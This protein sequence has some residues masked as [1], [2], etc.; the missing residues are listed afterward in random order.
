MSKKSHSNKVL[1]CKNSSIHVIDEI[2]MI[3]NQTYIF[4]QDSKCFPEAEIEYITPYP[5]INGIRKLIGKNK[6]TLSERE[7]IKDDLKS[8]SFV[9]FDFKS[10]KTKISKL[11]KKK[12]YGIFYF[13]F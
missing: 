3:E 4:T 2:L 9:K 11:I 5:T 10:H 8:L 12:K 7:I 1:N 13:L 6:L